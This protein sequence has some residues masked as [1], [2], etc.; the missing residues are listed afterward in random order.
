MV[1]PE[2]ARLAG[3]ARMQLAFALVSAALTVLAAIIPR[4]I[5]ELTGLNPDGGSGLLEWG[6]AVLFAAASIGFGIGSFR[7]RRRLAAA[8]G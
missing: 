3:R 2:E 6:L 8:R 7:T 1:A 4:W 5:E